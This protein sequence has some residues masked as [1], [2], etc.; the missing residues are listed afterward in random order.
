MNK[1]ALLSARFRIQGKE[2]QKIHFTVQIQIIK[3][4]KCLI[5][6]CGSFHKKP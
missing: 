5:M 1:Q 3:K 6:T 4:Y 2:K